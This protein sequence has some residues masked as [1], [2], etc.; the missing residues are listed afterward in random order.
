[1]SLPPHA[2]WRHHGADREGFEVVFF[3]EEGDEIVAR[4]R[5]TGIEEGKP[6]D[7]GYELRLG[8]DWRTRSAVVTGRSPDREGRLEVEADGE[9]AWTVDGVA[10]PE[11][12]GCLDLDLESSSLTNAFPVNRMGLEP[13][14]DSDAP[15]AYVKQFGLGVE[16]LEQRYRRID[17][18]EGPRRFDYLSVADDFR[19]EIVYDENGLAVEYPQIATRVL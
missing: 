15:A 10:V 19:V 11:V 6:F 9:G 1:V 7:V 18:G 13:G 12:E 4:G 2:A 14:A 3:G 17:D 16:R 8:R 5:T